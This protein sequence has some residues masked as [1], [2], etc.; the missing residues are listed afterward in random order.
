MSGFF[1]SNS[2]AFYQWFKTGGH[3]PGRLLTVVLAFLL[4]ATS[5]AFGLEVP[6]YKG[7]VNDYAGMISPPVAARLERALR[8]FDLSDSTQIAILTI[9]SLAGD[10]L[11]DFSIRV[12]DAWG[13][14][15]KDKDNGVL[16][17]AVK[18]E[19]KLR[20]E[21]GRGLEGVLT[22]LL[23]GRIIDQ[24]ITP[25]FKQGRF[26]EGFEAGTA[27][28]IQATRGEFKADTRRQ[29]TGRRQE[30]PP[31][32]TYLFLGAL[33]IGFL[34]QISKPLGVIGGAVLLPLIFFMGLTSS[35][36]ILMLLFLVPVGGIGGWLLP[37]LFAGSMRGRTGGFYMGGFGG[38][39]GGFSGSGGFG[40]F[41]GGGFGGGGASGGW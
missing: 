30:P 21:V 6:K 23:S 27:A 17:L 36:G 4:V 29:G 13:I 7:Y 20:I 33:F 38:S 35:F 28:I 11:E 39:R 41:G 3:S 34:G 12:V 24:I 31:I 32:L 5:A 1:M 15:Q 26:D 25:R 2:Q 14:G 16:L 18:K 10:S 22:D 40:G 8:S 9:D 19:R 37:L